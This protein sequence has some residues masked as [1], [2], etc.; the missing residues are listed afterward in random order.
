VQLRRKK[1]ANPVENSLGV[2]VFQPSKDL[3][4]EGF[5]NLFVKLPMLQ[6]TATNGTTGNIFQE[7]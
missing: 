7:T 3:R 2:E 5:G 4:G 1:W 6:E